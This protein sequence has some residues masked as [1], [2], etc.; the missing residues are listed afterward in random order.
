MVY[1]KPEP[2]DKWLQVHLILNGL[3]IVINNE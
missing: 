1:C 3:N 2:K